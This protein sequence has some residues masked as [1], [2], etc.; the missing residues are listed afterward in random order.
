[1][2]SKAFMAYM[3][4]H[5]LALGYVLSEKRPLKGVCDLRVWP[6]T[7]S[8]GQTGQPWCRH[9]RSA[10]PAQA[11]CRH[12]WARRWPGQPGG[13]C[14]EGVHKTA[15]KAGQQ[16]LLRAQKVHVCALKL[17]T[18]RISIMG[19]AVTWTSSAFILL[20]NTSR[21]YMLIIFG[22]WLLCA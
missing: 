21:L 12:F 16:Q 11:L 8:A 7:T 13:L 10:G 3:C 6:C 17:P 14:G 22:H 15:G 18:L 2:H 5:A 4:D 1:M 9:Q 19:C 20:L